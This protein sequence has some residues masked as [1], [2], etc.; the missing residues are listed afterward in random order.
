MEA[1]VGKLREQSALCHAEQPLIIVTEDDGLGELLRGKR[2]EVVRVYPDTEG[3]GI[4]GHDPSFKIEVKL[5]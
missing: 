1:R 2:L 3:A 5:S 4:R